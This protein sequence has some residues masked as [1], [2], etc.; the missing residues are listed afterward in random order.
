V[1]LLV[2]ESAPQALKVANEVR[3]NSVW[4][5]FF[6]VFI[7]PKTFSKSKTNIVVMLFLVFVRKI[8]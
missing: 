6:I 3:T 7:P 8:T 1:L 2:C 4:K 5:I